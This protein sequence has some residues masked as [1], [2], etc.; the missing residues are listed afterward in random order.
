MILKYRE[1]R[2]RD[3]AGYVGSSTSCHQVVSEPEYCLYISGKK[4]QEE[5]RSTLI[6]VKWYHNR[7]FICIIQV[8]EDRVV[9]ESVRIVYR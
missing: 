4:R 5:V 2:H 6:H 1:V 3:P 9:E 7:K 8:K